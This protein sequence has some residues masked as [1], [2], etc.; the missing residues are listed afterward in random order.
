MYG[1]TKR[2]FYKPLDIG[3]QL[4]ILNHY[5]IH[6]YSYLRLVCPRFPLFLTAFSKCSLQLCRCIAYDHTFRFIIF[7]CISSHF[8]IFKFHC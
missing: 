4:C 8:Y 5:H 2:H 1:I 6:R 7:L 3:I